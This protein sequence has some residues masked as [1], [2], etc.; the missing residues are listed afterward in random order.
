MKIKKILLGITC[1]VFAL[2]LTACNFSL[3]DLDNLKDGLG[4]LLD[5]IPATDS[6]NNHEHPDD[7]NTV[8]GI[9]YKELQFH[10]IEL[11]NEYTGDC[12][13]IKA[14]ELDILID[15]GSRKSSATAIK[16]YVDK[17]TKA[18]KDA[19][20][21]QF[22][23]SAYDC[24]YAIFNAMKAAIDSGKEISVDISASDLCEILKEQFEG[25]FTYTGVT[26]NDIKWDENGYVQKGA[27]KYVIK[28]ATK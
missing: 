26:G 14:G 28:E 18:Y 6:S 20:L 24:V 22:G 10:F 27:V 4:D 17:Y 7:T 5:E 2:T 8:E 1:F 16:E 13:Y 11:G 12:T 9:T 21:N 3:E 25:G 23:A 15:A 19:P